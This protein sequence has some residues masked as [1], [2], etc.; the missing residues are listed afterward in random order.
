MLTKPT[1][2]VPIAS[3]LYFLPIKNRMPLKFGPETT[4]EVTCAR[5]KLTVRDRDG[6]SADGWGET[7]LS[8]QWVWPSGLSYHERHEALKD[9]CVGLNEAWGLVVPDGPPGHPIEVGHRFLDGFLPSF[10]ASFNASERADK[11]PMPWLAA[12]VCASAFDLALHDAF[13][14]LHGVPTYLTYQSAYMNTDLAAYLTPADGSSVR[15]EGKYPEDFLVFPRPKTLP[16]WHLVGGKDPL[17]AA[18]LTG[19]E[20]EDEYPV[21]LADWIETDKLTCLKVKLRGDDEV[22]DYDRLVAVDAIGRA[23]RRVAHRRLQLHGQ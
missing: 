14:V 8:V 10:W 9:F 4:T 5:V 16:A 12:L 19:S 20:P 7:P 11:E 1:D 3:T 23:R 13:G 18:D 6:R 21:L 17:V 2:V 15:F 22:W